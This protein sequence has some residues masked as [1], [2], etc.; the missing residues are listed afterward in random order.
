[1]SEIPP[2]PRPLVLPVRSRPR[3]W[4]VLP[5]L[6]VVLVLA[7]LLLWRYVSEQIGYAAA[8][9]RQRAE[10]QW[11]REQLAALPEPA[12]RYRW[13]AKAL[14]PAVVGVKTEQIIRAGTDEL[15]A[16]FGFPRQYRAR[17][18]GSGVIVDEEGYVI[19]NYHVIRGA[20]RVDVELSDGRTVREVEIVGA[21]PLT[22]IAVLKIPPDGLTAAQWGESDQLEVGDPVLAIGSPFGLDQ[23]VTAG[24]ISAKGR[25]AVVEDVRYQDFIQ[26]DAALNPGNSGGPLVDMNA[27]VVGINTAI[28][29]QT[30]QGISFAIPSRLAREVYERLK[31][32]G[33]VE[34]GWLGVAM[35]EL[36]EVLARRLGLENLEG[37]LVAGV[38]ADSPADQAGIAPGDVIVRWNK[39]KITSPADL[40]LAVARSRIGSKATVELIREGRS[41]EKTL[42]VGRRPEQLP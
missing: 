4:P 32:T 1:M 9:G 35:Q 19:T 5:I 16:L 15:S 11:A 24:I 33:S 20:T 26:T 37:A 25:R 23:T 31:T 40:A 36:D 3:Q 41:L 18:Q 14:E 29:G 13:V 28:L 42:T 22:D 8:R 38:V 30:Y 10:A 21:D 12:N 39:E 6:L 17:G 34:R 7:A 27:K 2:P